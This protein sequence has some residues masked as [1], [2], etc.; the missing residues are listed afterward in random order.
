MR[1][2][3]RKENVQRKPKGQIRNDA[4]Y[5]GGDCRQR[6]AQRLILAQ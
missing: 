1:C 6:S 5:C 3:R 2:N 4:D